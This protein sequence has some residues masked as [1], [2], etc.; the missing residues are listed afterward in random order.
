MSAL[1]G[2]PFIDNAGKFDELLLKINYN[3]KSLFIY[4]NSHPNACGYNIMA[5]EIAKRISLIVKN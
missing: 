1:A 3:Y 5:N 4:D 2:V